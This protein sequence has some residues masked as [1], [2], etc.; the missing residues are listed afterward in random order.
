MKDLKVKAPLTRREALK[1]R[2]LGEGDGR[3]LVRQRGWVT[4]FLRGKAVKY[5]ALGGEGERLGTYNAI[6]HIVEED[7]FCFR[8]SWGRFSRREGDE[9]HRAERGKKKKESTS[10]RSQTRPVW[11]REGCRRRRRQHL[12]CGGKLLVWRGGTEEGKGGQGSQKKP[13]TTDIG[14]RSKWR[15]GREKE[16]TLSDPVGRGGQ[17]RGK[18]NERL[19]GKRAQLTLDRKGGELPSGSCKKEVEVAGRKVKSEEKKPLRYLYPPKGD[20]RR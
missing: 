12:L 18:K 15:Q 9:R 14:R 5:Q 11:S 13:K 3:K 17:S 7:D 4:E 10:V 2:I 6:L 1:R 16:T 19:E 20:K 8:T